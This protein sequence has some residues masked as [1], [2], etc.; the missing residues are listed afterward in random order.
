MA[1]NRGPFNAL[2]DDDG[3]G[4]TGTPWNKAQIAGVILDP[5]DA[6]IAG[7]PLPP[8]G[9]ITVLG[10]GSGTSTN[11]VPETLTFIP[12]P[13]LTLADAVLVSGVAVNGG[14]APIRLYL[15]WYDPGTQTIILALELTGPT[16]AGTVATGGVLTWRALFR[17]TPAGP[18]NMQ[19]LASAVI[20][21]GTGQS[22]GNTFGVL[23]T[24]NFMS[25]GSGYLYY[26][27]DG[28]AGTMPWS[29]TVHLLKGAT[30][31]VGK[32]APP[33]GE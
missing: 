19:G 2:V 26:L 1:I 13:Q 28:V 30:A 14:S 12:V 6:A 5:V 11:P 15:N 7:I 33:E 27:H 16:V 20:T 18:A 10:S 22:L 4:T 25:A 23:S 29:W 8:A 3:T 21:L 32:P 31:A 24:A 17:P 9:P